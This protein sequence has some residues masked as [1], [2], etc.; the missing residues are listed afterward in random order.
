MMVWPVVISVFSL[1]KTCFELEEI[2]IRMGKFPK[3]LLPP[4]W[5]N[6]VIGGLWRFVTIICQIT[7]IVMF[8]MFLWLTFLS[9]VWFGS[10]KYNSGSEISDIDFFTAREDNIAKYY[11]YVIPI[12]AFMMLFIVNVWAKLKYIGFNDE[13]SIAYGFLCAIVPIK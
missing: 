9:R 8:L 4:Y 12:S 1:F 13:S 6:L 3:H 2:D 10:K 7:S 11:V 5:S